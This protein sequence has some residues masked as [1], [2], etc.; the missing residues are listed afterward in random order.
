MSTTEQ[1]VSSASLKQEDVG[2]SQNGARSAAMDSMNNDSDR[3][4]PTTTPGPLK[5]EVTRDDGSSSAKDG[6]E[7]SSGS[8]PG[9]ALNKEYLQSGQKRTAT[10]DIKAQSP[11]YDTNGVNGGSRRERSTTT[12]S[13]FRGNNRIAE[14]WVSVH[15]VRHDC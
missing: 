14:V 9:D 13:D 2:S 5:E 11:V 10:G 15:A 6:M 8:V 12:G 1:S 7:E 4:E 3:F